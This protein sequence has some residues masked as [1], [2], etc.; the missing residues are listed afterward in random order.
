MKV[1]F[2]HFLPAIVWFLI[3][4]ILLMLP[5]KDLPKED[6]LSGI[7]FDKWV[8]AGLFGGLVFLFNYPFRNNIGYKSSFYI[9]IVIAAIIY[10]IAMEFAQKY[11]TA[12]RDFDVNDMVADAA[13]AILG[14]L[15]FRLVVVKLQ[16]KNKPL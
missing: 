12:D 11:L 4:F 3:I 8:H 7:Y 16:R 10:G 2:V 1:K 14:Y 9:S 6:F 15:F 13:G 5:G